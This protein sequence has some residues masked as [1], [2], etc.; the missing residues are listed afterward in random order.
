MTR[1]ALLFGIV[2]I[3]LALIAMFYSGMFMHGD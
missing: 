3:G 2:G 1:K